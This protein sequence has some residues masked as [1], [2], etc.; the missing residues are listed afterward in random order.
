[1]GK[2]NMWT[3]GFC[4]MGSLMQFF[5]NNNISSGILLLSLGIIN[6]AIGVLNSD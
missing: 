5:T 3:S 4:T 2:F 6:L 1:M